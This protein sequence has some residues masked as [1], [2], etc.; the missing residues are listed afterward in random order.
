[1]VFRHLW[2]FRPRKR[3][4]SWSEPRTPIAAI[5]SLEQRALL[6]VFAVGPGQPFDSLGAV[7]WETL[8]PGDS[9]EIHWRETPY[10]EKILISSS[11][12][13]DRPLKII[14]VPG[15]LGERPIIDGDG[16]TT[17]TQSK[18]PHLNTEV[19]GLLT[20]SRDAADPYGF[21]PSDIEIS[22]LE[23]RN[24]HPD[25]S[26]I[27]GQGIQ[28]AYA[29]NAAAIFVERGERITICDCQI[30]DSANGLFVASGD[31]E[32]S[33]SRNILVDGNSFEGNGN[34]GS[35]REHHIYTEASGIVFQNNR[36]NEL[37]P[38]SL[39]IG[40]KDRSAGTVIRNN[41]IAGGARLLDLVDP[42]D[43]YALMSR[44]PDFRRTV[45]YGNVFL[46]GPEDAGTLIHYGGDSGVTS[47]YRKGM[48][49]FYHNT[50]VI[51]ADQG[52]RYNT[53]LFE[54]STNDEAVDLRNNVVFVTPTTPGAVPTTL[55]LMSSFGKLTMGTNW[56]SD[57]WQTSMSYGGFFGTIS[58]VDSQ[59]T[60]FANDP[61]FVDFAHGDLRPAA[62]S[63][64][65]DQAGP[66]H[67]K[68]SRAFPATQQIAIGT[69]S[70]EARLQRGQ[71]SDLGAFES[72]GAKSLGSPEPLPN[73]NPN[74]TL[75]LTQLSPSVRENSGKLTMTVS[76]IGGTS[77]TVRVW[78]DVSAD[79]AQVGTDFRS[80]TGQL[81]FRPGETKKTFSIRIVNDSQTERTES[82][83]VRLFDVS[84]G[85]TL[86]DAS[87]IV[88]VHDD[89]RATFQFVQSTAS[90]N[91]SDDGLS[92]EFIRLGDL[93]DTIT[94]NVKA[95]SQTAQR[96]IDFELPVT[97]ITL[98]P[99]E[100]YGSVW[101][102][103]LDDSTRESTETFRLEL[104][105]SMST[106]AWRRVTIEILDDDL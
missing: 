86:A 50:V 81:T 96:A 26:F 35:D 67:K 4:G 38:G 39:G 36:I 53:R 7:P 60:N 14:G 23:F 24:A 17:R 101:V 68:I 74:G 12:T 80:S 77:G 70:T 76:R 25:Y 94:V 20:V 59:L 55:S 18:Y 43:S 2:R 51:Q 79:T 54:L 32:A 72:N 95:V 104:P 65:E 88:W 42:E 85:A 27:D 105:T 92:L 5:E 3:R 30:N 56:L 84:G 48:L 61:G 6:A 82:F 73:Q 69:N 9:V 40:L 102:G 64:L 62:G 21:K 45:V 98:N 44:E 13:A 78:Y 106:S 28:R 8:G 66:L 22:G 71:K 90:V 75:R 11:G 46:N 49:Y 31:E 34:V 52:Q 47:G 37:R 63:A 57:G 29:L 100:A 16:A 103:L 19:R 91:E 83:Y 93:R 97:S 58:G 41:V 87:A 99:G 33:F 1:M 10:R 89:E 15:P